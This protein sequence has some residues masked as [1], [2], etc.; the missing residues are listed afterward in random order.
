MLPGAARRRRLKRPTDR[1]ALS[2]PKPPS[3]QAQ[4]WSEGLHLTKQWCEFSNREQGE[5]R[6]EFQRPWRHSLTPVSSPPAKPIQL[7]RVGH[8]PSIIAPRHI[9]LSI[10]APEAKSVCDSRQKGDPECEP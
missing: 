9:G 6:R 7:S 3:S 8:E 2:L 1:G 5:D 10:N 4:R